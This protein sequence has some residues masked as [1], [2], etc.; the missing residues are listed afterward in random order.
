LLLSE[1]LALVVELVG[2]ELLV[3]IVVAHVAQQQAAPGGKPGQ[4][5]LEHLLKVVDA[6]KVLADRVDQHRVELLVGQLPQLVGLQVM[7]GYALLPA[8][9]RWPTYCW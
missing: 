7:E 5:L 8:Y 2:N 3:E 4:D 1:G 6:G 9:V